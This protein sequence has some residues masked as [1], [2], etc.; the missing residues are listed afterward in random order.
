MELSAAT[1]HHVLTYLD[2]TPSWEL[3]CRLSGH[4]DGQIAEAA[5]D[6]ATTAADAPLEVLRG[7]ARV[8]LVAD[9]RVSSWSHVHAQLVQQG[10][11]S[12]YLGLVLHQASLGPEPF[13]AGLVARPEF[14]DLARRCQDHRSASVAAVA[15]AALARHG[16]TT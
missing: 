3:L 2:D 10:H 4:P 16:A 14:A 13:L 15:R 5:V 9:G 12:R 6:A 8:A 1:R 11:D 7:I